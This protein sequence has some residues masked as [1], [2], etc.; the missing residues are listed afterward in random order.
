VA[1]NSEPVTSPDQ[2]K[3]TNLKAVRAGGI[4]TIGILLVMVIGNHEGNVENIWLIGLALLLAAMLIGDWLL[5]KNGLKS[6]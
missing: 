4:I 1:G 6:G 3:P 5:R 2:H